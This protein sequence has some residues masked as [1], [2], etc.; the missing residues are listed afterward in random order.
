M[1]FQ[2]WIDFK[3]DLKLLPISDPPCRHCQF[4]GP[5]RKYIGTR[6]DGVSL[7]TKYDKTGNTQ[8]ADFSC[9]SASPNQTAGKKEE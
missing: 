8:E 5:H 6:F 2:P 9:Y 1:K 3:E 7:C 4:W